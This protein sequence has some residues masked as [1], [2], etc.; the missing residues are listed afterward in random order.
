MLICVKEINDNKRFIAF[1]SDG[2]TTKFGQIN[3]NI[4]TYT[5]HN[6]KNLEPII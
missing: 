2:S 5:D 3:P 1:F 4:G 6:D